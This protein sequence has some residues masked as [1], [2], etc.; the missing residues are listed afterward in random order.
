MIELTERQLGI[1]SVSTRYIPSPRA[2]ARLEPS[3]S[4][5]DESSYP[6]S[7]PS[8]T[9]TEQ[10]ALSFTIIILLVLYHIAVA[11]TNSKKQSA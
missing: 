11:D 9:T 2:L 10:N 8:H 5:S 1:F 3:N 7:P 4:A 6:H